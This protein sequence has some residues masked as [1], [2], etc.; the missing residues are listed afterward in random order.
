MRERLKV[1]ETALD[2]EHKAMDAEQKRS[3]LN[4]P[5]EGRWVSWSF[6]FIFIALTIGI[7]ASG[8]F[9]YKTQERQLRDATNDQLSAVADLKVKQIVAWR[10]DRI[11][12]AT[13]I[14]KQSVFVPF[15]HQ[16]LENPADS[17]LKEKVSA[18]LNIFQEAENYKAIFLADAQGNTRISLPQRDTQVSACIK[19]YFS[20]AMRT[21]KIVF[22]DFHFVATTHHIHL[23]LI[24]PLFDFDTAP[25]GFIVLEIDP[26]QFLYPLIQTWPT[27]SETAET[28]L[29]RRE[30]NEVVFL[31]ELRHRKNTALT[32]RIP[33]S[34]KDLPAVMAVKGKTGMVEGVDYRGVPVFAVLRKI[35][36]SP[37]FLVSKI[38]VDEANAL[39]KGRTWAVAIIVTLLIALSG[40]GFGLLWRH[41]RGQFYKRHYERERK[42]A[43][44]RRQG[45]EH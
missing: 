14:M 17:N 41:Q 40:A 18:W 29:V 8:Y 33:I 31:N 5:R 2:E 16:W 20:E 26:Y 43:I 42:L 7:G 15:V 36:D 45:E 13:L 23:A 37:W 30:G 39:L 11:E 10:D 34:R 32:L 44:E 19:E 9:Y 27:P 38:D 12:D 1:R 25:F 28:L 4:R 24:I 3:N 35:P 22:T 6:L 21:R